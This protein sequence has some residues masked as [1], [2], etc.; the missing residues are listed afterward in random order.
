MT[1]LGSV[2]N[3]LVMLYPYCPLANDTLADLFLQAPP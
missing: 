1:P 2:Y 3:T